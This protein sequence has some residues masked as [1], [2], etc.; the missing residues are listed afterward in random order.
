MDA[1]NQ[2]LFRGDAN[3]SKHAARHLTEQGLNYIQPRTVLGR[4]HKLE[5]LTMQF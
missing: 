4:E 1:V 3:L 5:P 2:L